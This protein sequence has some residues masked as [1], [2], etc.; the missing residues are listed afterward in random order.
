[1]GISRYIE[2]QDLT[3]VVADGEK[4]VQNTE[5]ER[6]DERRSP[7]EACHIDGL[8]HISDLAESVSLTRL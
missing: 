6:W 2:M 8:H 5:S 1:M 7:L 4:A 3:P